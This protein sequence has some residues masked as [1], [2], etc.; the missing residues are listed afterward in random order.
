AELATVREDFAYLLP[1]GIDDAHAA[2]LL[3]AG[4]I[5]YRALVRSNL[6]DGGTLGIFGFG[7]SAHLVIQ[8]ARHRGCKVF[9]VTRGKEHQQLALRLGADWA[10]ENA[11]GMPGKVDSAIIFAPAAEL[12]PQA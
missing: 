8:I 3:C 1:P 7:Q 6:P 9:V 5:G 10:S 12:I 4:I 2:P 11:L